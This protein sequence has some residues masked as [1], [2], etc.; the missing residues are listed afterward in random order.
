MHIDPKSSVPIYRQI[1]SGVQTAIESGVYKPGECL[2][3]LRAMA[4]DIGVN[5]NTVQRAYDALEREGTLESRRG[6]GV[7]V[8]DDAAISAK[9]AKEKRISKAL[10]QVVRDAFRDDI[11]I[12]RLRSLFESA[13]SS[14]RGHLRRRQN[15]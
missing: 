6:V 11:S 3:S 5:P 15:D 9:G 12:D 2:P 7:F 10:K 8:T 13:L 14:S 4:L 1:V